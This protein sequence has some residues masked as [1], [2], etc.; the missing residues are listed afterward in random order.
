M[1][2]SILIKPGLC[3]PFCGGPSAGQII[4][5]H[6]ISL[7]LQDP[8]FPPDYRRARRGN[9]FLAHTTVKTLSFHYPLGSPEGKPTLPLERFIFK[10]VRKGPTN[11]QSHFFR[12]KGGY[13]APFR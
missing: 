7:A 3:W 11:H 9:M 8:I 5:D 1:H 6:R 10:A 2:S 13:F 12:L 4:S